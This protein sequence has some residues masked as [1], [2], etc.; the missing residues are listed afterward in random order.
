M[1]HRILILPIATVVVTIVIFISALV[2]PV[3]NTNN[4]PGNASF[5]SWLISLFEKTEEPEVPPIPEP[6][7]TPTPT[8]SPA[9]SPS[10]IPTPT[11]APTPTPSP[12]P[13]PTPV[14]PVSTNNL[15][16]PAIGVT[17]PLVEL[18]LTA[19][20]N[21]A[22]PA[23]N[24]EVG[25]WKGSAQPGHLGSPV[26]LTGHVRGVFSKLSRLNNGD[27]MTVTYG[28]KH[29]TYKVVH[30]ETVRLSKL[31]MA[32]PLTVYGGGQEGMNLMTCA[33]SYNIFTGTYTKRLTV[34]TVRIS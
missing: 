10:P 1:R 26:F 18:G 34:Y 6:T 14:P 12:S 5:W 23:S 28:G 11:P 33:G 9:P 13:T 20:N 2:S 22:S 17:A 24:T 30:K 4:H 27:L 16:I 25:R 8:P 29:F 3:T 19:S 21:I 32:K 7:P 15:S 31:D